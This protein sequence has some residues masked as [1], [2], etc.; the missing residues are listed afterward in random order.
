MT[1]NL[2]E[3]TNAAGPILS[4]DLGKYKSVACIYYSAEDTRF[5]TITTSRTELTRLI[6]KHRP[7]VIL[8]EAC[9][10]CGW[11]RDSCVEL[12]IVCLV[13]NTSTPRFRFRHLFVL[14][15]LPI[16]FLGE[17]GLVS[18][19]LSLSPLLI[20]WICGVG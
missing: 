14:T 19:Q 17:F 10:L 8:I 11:V 4:L 20:V 18:I 1:T 6:A 2:S 9:L 13:A 7:S 12:E 16:E 5:T 15:C 3:L